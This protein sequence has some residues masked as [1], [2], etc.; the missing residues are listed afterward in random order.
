MAT[1]RDIAGACGVSPSVVSYVINNSRPV[2]P[3]T[4]KKILHA[5]HEMSYHPSALARGLSRKKMNLIGV[6]FSRIFSTPLTNPFFGP[7]LDGIV[8]TGMDRQQSTA[9][10]TWPTWEEIDAHH[11]VYCDGRVDGLILIAP[12]TDSPII[13]TLKRRGIPFVVVAQ[14][15]EQEGITCIDIDNVGAARQAI[16]HLL[17]LG[18]RRIA[19]VSGDS[20]AAGMQARTNGFRQAISNA[21]IHFDEDLM[22]EG[23]CSLR[24]VSDNV[25]QLLSLPA[26]KRPTAI[27]FGNDELALKGITQIEEHGFRVPKD[28]SVIGFDDIAAAASSNPPLT[29]IRQPLNLY[30]QTA[31]TSLL[32]QMNHGLASGIPCDDVKAEFVVRQSTGRVAEA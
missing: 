27:F 30:G 20:W 21:G 19:M 8:S 1:I 15:V 13:S 9:F 31:V 11:T 29:T 6:I 14:T 16:D 4:R 2:A 28:I 18:H 3:K 17:A 32:D 7:I 26:S 5:M 25:A 12:N 24:T 22:C 23:S 10:F